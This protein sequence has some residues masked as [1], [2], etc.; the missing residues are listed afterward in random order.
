MKLKHIMVDLETLGVNPFC[1]IL[2]IGAL[3][4][5]PEA[6]GVYRD[7]FEV[8]VDPMSSVAAG[9]RIEPET[10]FWWWDEARDTPR[11]HW[12]GLLKFDLNAA[13]HGFSQWMDTFSEDKEKHSDVRIWGN[14]A[15]FDN[16]RLAEAYKVANIPA[17]WAFYQDRCFRTIRSLD[18]GYHLKPRPGV[19]LN[20]GVPHTALYDCFQQA[21][22]M[23]NIVA[24]HKLGVE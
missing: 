5:D 9:L 6:P 20:D 11:K 1:V 18:K 12:M 21:A 14:G 23:Q 10:N 3:H 22:W 15:N 19:A 16:V 2:S 8:A 17:P 4:F 7:S 24:A 13:L